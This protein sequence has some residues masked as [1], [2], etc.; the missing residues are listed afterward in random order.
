MDMPHVH[1]DNTVIEGTQPQQRDPTQAQEVTPA[2]VDR[3][4]C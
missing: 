3:Q 1:V 4:L 2:Q